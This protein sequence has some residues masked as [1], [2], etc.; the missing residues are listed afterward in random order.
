MKYAPKFS[1]IIPVYNAEKYIGCCISSLLKQSFHNF[2]IICVDD[3]STDNSVKIIENIHDTRIRLL[4]NDINY[5]PAEARNVGVKYATGEYLYFPDAD[6]FCYPELLERLNRVFE[7]NKNINIVEFMFNVGK[8][9]ED[10]CPAQ[11]LFRGEKGVRTVADSDIMLATAAW[12]KAY[13]RSFYV[14][15]GFSFAAN[16]SGGEIPMV[17]S[18]LLKAQKFYYLNYPGYFW[19][20]NSN[21]FSRDNKRLGRFLRGTVRMTKALKKELIR[22]GVYD[23]NQYRVMVLRILS[24]SI[25]EKKS[26]SAAFRL[27]CLYAKF[28]YYFSNLRKRDFIN[29]HSADIRD[30][31]RK[32]NIIMNFKKLLKKIYSKENKSKHIV[33]RL[34]GVK[35]KIRIKI[36]EKTANYSFLQKTV[37]E[38]KQESENL[39]Q[40]LIRVTPQAKL[41]Y[42]VV[43]LVDECNLRCKGCDH[44]APLA[45]GGYLEPEVFDKDMKRLGELSGGEVNRIGLMGGEALL[46][47]RICEFFDIAR[48]Y[49]SKTNIQ[50][51]TNGLLLN[52]KKEDFWLSCRKNDIEIVNTK[53]PLKLDFEKMR[54][55]A[56]KYGVR[57]KHFTIE[58]E[59]VKT[60]YKIPLAL[61]EEQ[62]GRENFMSCF[63]A[64][65]CT[66]LKSGRMYTCTVAP[67]I[68]HFNKYFGKKI[69]LTEQDS[70][71]IYKAKDMN[72]ILEFLSRPIPFCRF[73]NVK[74]RSFGHSWARSEQDISEW[75]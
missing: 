64:N 32:R 8:S 46:H 30:F 31:Y 52:Q 37:N 23:K 34:F 22:A 47:P 69:P 43:H 10:C 72:E 54:V 2:E 70:I 53:Y 42:F 12:N 58:G 16:V 44:F 61:S 49:F 4:K 27:F 15:N 39:R 40:S 19:R 35:I 13:R 74:G 68:V 66:M 51:V 5:G 41:N 6:D 73:C 59:A 45:K 17:L 25:I 24:W 3:A 50:V 1:V 75:A 60:S 56:E 57:F 29:F 26:N 28:F 38:L 67:N 11:Y 20:V 7:H 14:E 71:D 48:K 33:V 65:N 63:H 18:S 36:P 55:T 21:S 9:T 62:N